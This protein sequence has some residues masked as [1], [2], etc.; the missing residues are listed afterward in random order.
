MTSKLITPFIIFLFSSILNLFIKSS[1]ASTTYNVLSFGAKPNGQIDATQSFLNAWRAACTSVEPSTIYVPKGRYLIK[2]ATFRGPCKSKITV[3]I[4]GT[5]VAPL[6]YWGI[7]NSGYWILFIE[8][9]GISVIGGSI[10]AKGDGFWA[11]RKSGNN[12]CPVG[13]RS[14][15]FNWANDVVVSGLLSINSQVTHLVINSCNNVM[16][17]NVKVIAPDQSPNTD[18]IHVQSST[19]VTII[20][21]RIKTGDDCISIGPGTRNLWME[22]ILC[23]PGH[24]VSIG[25]L[26]REYEEDGVQNVT[27]SYS[28]FTGSDNGLRIKSW[29]RPSTSFV[30]NINYR[31]IVMKYVDNPIIIDQNYC[32]NNKDCPQQTSGVKINDVIYKNIEG[33]STT[34]VAMNFD[35]S[36]SNPCQGIQI[37]DIKLTYMNK[38]AKSFCNNIQGTKKGV[39]WPATCI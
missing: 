6:D 2:E 7:G 5:L 1:N 36:P 21:C 27:L 34:E 24:G 12:N 28:I 15:T 39:I 19:N 10:D 20:G 16:V 30:K 37:Q 13:A 18:G 35:C 22:K 3:K 31:N 8:V 11:C 9:N 23:G 25:S 38:K 14:I 33:T 17:K 29:A 4:D 26:G 32:P